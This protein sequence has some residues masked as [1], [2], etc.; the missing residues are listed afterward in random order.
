[1]NKKILTLVLVLP[2]FLNPILAFA[3]H[4]PESILTEIWR[5]ATVPY[6][7]YENRVNGT[8]YNCT[9]E[10]AD[11]ISCWATFLGDD[12]TYQGAL[13]LLGQL[14][15]SNTYFDHYDLPA[16]NPYIS[17]ENLDILVGIDFV[18]MW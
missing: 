9:E 17:D 11:W 18:C 4:I 16:S 10:D 14:K 5:E 6:C 7:L 8:D 2:W 1:M 15:V 13:D 3:D 12:L